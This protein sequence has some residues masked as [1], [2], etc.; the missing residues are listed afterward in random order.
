MHKADLGTITIDKLQYW[1][2][3]YGSALGMTFVLPSANLDMAYIL[4]AG[5]HRSSRYDFHNLI[6]SSLTRIN[7]G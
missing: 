3:S 4:R 6:F 5:L 1:G 2:V 7:L